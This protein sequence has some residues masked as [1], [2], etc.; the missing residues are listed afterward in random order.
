VLG[1][2][3]ISPK[4]CGGLIEFSRQL[5]LQAAVEQ[6]VRNELLRTVGTLVDQ[7]VLNGTG[8]AG[9]PLGLLNTAGLATQSGTALAHTGAVAMKTSC[10]NA[11]ARDESIAFLTTPTVRGLLE[12]RERGTNG[13]GFIWDN[14]RIASRP[15]YAT[16]DMP[17]GGMVAGDFA[18]VLLALWGPGFEVSLNP[19]E[20][21]KFQQG[22]IQARLVVSLDVAVGHP[23]AFT[24]AATV[25]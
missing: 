25:T 18:D 22:I 16:T 1:Q 4:S 21:G 24:V 17:A 23:G 6:Y 5:S 12:G 19:Y 14:D 2:I 9:Q 10:A 15:G 8:A 3:A 11:N 13:D 7:A 20:Q